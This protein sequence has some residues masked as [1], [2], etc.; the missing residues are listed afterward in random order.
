MIEGFD[1]EQYFEDMVKMEAEYLDQFGL[2]PVE[3][4]DYNDLKC[5]FENFKYECVCNGGSAAFVDYGYVPF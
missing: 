5:W 1:R 2:I 4:S 3:E